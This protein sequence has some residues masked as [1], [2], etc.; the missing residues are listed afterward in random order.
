[1][2]TS[3]PQQSKTFRFKIDDHVIYEINSFAKLHQYDDKND[4]KE[5]WKEWTE[6]NEELIERESRRLIELGYMGDVKEKLYKSGRYYYRTKST[7]KTEP[8]KRRNYVGL[9]REFIDNID[10]HIN[11][12]K[13]NENYKPSEGYDDFCKRYIAEL[14]SEIELIRQNGIVDASEISNKIKKAYK[15]RCFQIIKKAN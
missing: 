13:E 15:N 7:Q 5:A 10:Q 1:M 12:H 6:T 8:I 3:T 11:M 4:Y 2:T 14:K 9:T